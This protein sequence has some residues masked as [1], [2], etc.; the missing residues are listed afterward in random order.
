[1]PKYMTTVDK[2]KE[3][4]DANLKVLTTQIDSNREIMS[5]KLNEIKEDVTEVKEHVQK[6]NGHVAANLAR[7]NE[8]EKTLTRFGQIWKSRGYII[9]IFTLLIVVLSMIGHEIGLL[10]LIGLI[11]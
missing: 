8:T 5:I 11:K 1:M 2:I 4:L 6:T 7:I 10:E 9:T 3:V